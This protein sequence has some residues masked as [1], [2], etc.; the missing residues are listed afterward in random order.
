MHN[1]KWCVISY[2]IAETPYWQ[3]NLIPPN[4]DVYDGWKKEKDALTFEH[5]FPF[6]MN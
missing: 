5:P 2:V 3:I 4:A 6:K 1:S